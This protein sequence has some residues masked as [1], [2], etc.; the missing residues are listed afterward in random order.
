MWWVLF[1]LY[2]KQTVFY[3]NFISPNWWVLLGH[4]N[5]LKHKREWKRRK[6]DIEQQNI[7]DLYLKAPPEVYRYHSNTKCK[8]DCVLLLTLFHC[9]KCQRE[10]LSLNKNRWPVTSFRLRNVAAGTF[11]CSSSPCYKYKYITHTN[12]NTECECKCS[13]QQI[14]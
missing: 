11:P 8:M 3:M 4:D 7:L 2:C 6:H 10:P 5:P 12:W 14:S 13:H 9:Q 1:L